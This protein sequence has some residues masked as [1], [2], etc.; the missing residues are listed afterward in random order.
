[1]SQAYE[2]QGHC[3][4]RFA[5][6]RDAFEHNFAQG[7]EAGASFAAVLDGELV[8]DL[9]GGH[10]DAQGERAWQA[11]TIVN[12][13]STTKAMAALCTLMLVDRGALDLDAPVAKVWPEFAEAG[14][15]SVRVRQLL[16]HTSG[17]PGWDA[18]LGVD[19]L[20]DWDRVCG[21]L[22]AQAPWWEPGTTSGY[23]ALTHGFLLGEVVRRVEGRS[24]GAF[25]RKEVAEPLG[26]DFHIG[27]AEEHEGRVGQML[28]PLD[29]ALAAGAGIEPGS[30]AERVL[31]NPP[32]TGD[33]ANR[34]AWR[35]AEIPAANG[36]G[37]ARSVARIAGALACG[38]TLDGVR[39]LGPA[40]LERTIEEQC[41]ET[42]LVLGVP[43]RWGLGFGLTAKELPIGPN[44][45]TFFWGGWGGSLVVVDL[46]ARLGFAY[47][48]N[49]MGA[50]TMGDLRA[51]GPALATFGAL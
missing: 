36:Q 34:R 33:V 24:L 50:T 23:H 51:F 41:Y 39:L 3:S 7:L 31:G 46:D 28:P 32:L 11:D 25:F 20:Y 29:S 17:L 4:P 48:M 27:L 22:A 10:A 30:V 15:A 40:T 5:A 47:V 35:A 21:L 42:D 26:A 8:V 12:V 2:I 13:Y 49:K 45:R 38:G 37:N 19:D 9:W 6:V 14:K 1:M 44:P 18:A 16:S 43:I